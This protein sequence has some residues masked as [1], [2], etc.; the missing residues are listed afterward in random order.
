MWK[1]IFAAMLVVFGFVAATNAGTD[2]IRDYGADQFKNSY[3]YA[4]APL[5]PPRPL[6]YAPPPPV[7]VVL[8]PAYGYVG[9]RYCGPRHCGRHAFARPYYAR[10]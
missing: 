3:S 4:P 9:A 1:K 7:N 5:P 2:V 10:R 8:F 6:Y